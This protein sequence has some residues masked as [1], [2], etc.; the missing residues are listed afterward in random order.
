MFNWKVEIE[1]DRIRFLGEEYPL[2]HFCLELLQHARVHDAAARV[3]VL[4]DYLDQH[5]RELQNGLILQKQIKEIHDMIARVL[6]DLETLPPFHLTGVEEL[7][8][9][10]ETL[11]T[12]EVAEQ[13][14][15]YAKQFHT[16]ALDQAEL[17]VQVHYDLSNNPI[18][19]PGKQL[20]E[21]EK[22]FLSEFIQ[23]CYD[24]GDVDSWLHRFVMRLN[25]LESTKPE[26]LFWLA[27]QIFRSPE[28]SLQN[29]YLEADSDTSVRHVEFTNLRAF[30]LTDFFEGLAHNHYPRRCPVCKGS[31]R[32]RF[33]VCVKNAVFYVS[34]H[35]FLGHILNDNLSNLWIIY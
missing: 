33:G 20:L 4:W 32:C 8:Q 35:T 5:L 30:L 11:F 28:L 9:S 1:G 31:F 22:A 7:R 27:S 24:L 25:E 18:R 34:S 3:G 15:D 16:R 6:P 26:D 2:G 13:I 19:H 12:E 21:Q 17:W 14:A 23:L 29:H 10:V